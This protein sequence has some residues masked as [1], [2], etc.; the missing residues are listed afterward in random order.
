LVLA[1]VLVAIPNLCLPEAQN[2]LL[3]NLVAAAVERTHH[4]VRY[5]S[6]YVRIRYPG[7]DVP[8]DTGVC[9]DEIIRSYRAVGIDLQKEVHEDMMRNFAVYPHRWLRRPDSNIDH[10]RVPNLMVFFARKGS[11]LPISQRV[12]DY[13]PGD[14]VAWDLGGGVTHIGIVVD[15]KESGERYMIVHN[16]GRGPQME[17]VLFDWKII[18]HYR[19]FGP[20][21]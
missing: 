3:R 6:D 1:G 7:G 14:L 11:E 20:H 9:T 21:S 19:Y 16:I 5:V 13:S 15:R 2:E 10:R 4:Q 12:Q 18:G 8:A 17:D